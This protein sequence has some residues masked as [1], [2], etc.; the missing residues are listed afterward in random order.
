MKLLRTL[1]ILAL[2]AAAA[3]TQA[4]DN[5]P[6]DM[7]AAVK[8]ADDAVAAIVAVPDS[9]RTFDNTIGA[10][11]DLSDHLQ[12]D[13]AFFTF[14]QFVSTDEKTRD[15]SRA[16]DEYI[17]NWE[18]D[19][20]KR[21]D[22]YKAVKAYADTNPKLEGEQHRLLVFTLRDFRR[23]GMELTQD[24]RDKL[25]DDDAQIEKLGV[26]YNQ[27]INDDETTVAFTKA[28]LAGVPQ[29]A[30]DGM[31]K[32]AGLVLFDMAEPTYDA[33]EDNATNESTRQKYWLAFKRRGGEK[34]VSILQ[35]LLVLRAEEASIL[36]YKTWADYVAEPRMAKN[37]ATIAKFYETLQPIVR[38]KALVDWQLFLSTKRKDTH[39]P[40]ADFYPWD[41]GYYKTLLMKQKYAVDP[42]TVAEYFPM[43]RVVQGLFDVTSRLYDI[44]FKEVT[45]DAPKL[46]LPIWNPDVKLY[47]VDDNKTHQTLGHLYMDLYPRPNKYSHDA[48]WG[49]IPRRVWNDGTVQKPVAAMVCNLT[50]ST[51][52][53]PSLLQHDEV[54]TIFHEFG[55]GL[56]NLLTD[57]HYSRFAGTSVELDFVEAP[58]QMM[59]NWVWQPEVLN[60]F[61][62]NYKTGKP[63]PKSLLD[64]MLAARSLG[65]GMETE[66]QEYYGIV[67][68]IYHTAPGGKI[69]TTEVGID[70][71]HKIELYQGV[72]GTYYE[73]SFEH[74][75]GYDA[76]YY[77]Y[78]WSLVYAQDMFQ[79]FKQLGLLSPATGAYYR[80]KVLSRGGTEDA[81]V[82]LH[83][84]LGRAP[85]MDAF[86]EYLG[87]RK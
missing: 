28:E 31:Q 85:K 78:L 68:Q 59:E 32:S 62:R 12:V 39:N 66:H 33:L 1:P 2:F 40:R 43:E 81:F 29:D 36:G 8:R 84:Y 17:S 75:I 49:L 45:A 57:A 10:I 73:A 13:T 72:P 5:V 52:T 67:D 14:M 9:N 15:E 25:K 23:S 41:Y 51:P 80:D 79:R 42:N 86:L 24:K 3:I 6:D 60:L 77:S 20:Y 4:Q 61:A 76:A 22:L 74:F 19:L 7:K 56:H 50:K 69:D 30:I 26:D 53:K 11:D 38:K 63:F 21:N 54:E 82:M 70:E 65:S 64:G 58:S 44:S 18:N 46:N 27:N 34:N 47:E 55:H 16:S 35:K 48:C 83:N 71:M 37:Q 87:L